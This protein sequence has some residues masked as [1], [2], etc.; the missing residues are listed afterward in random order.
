[1]LAPIRKAVVAGVGAGFFAGVAGLA[2]AMADGALTVAEATIAGGLALGALASV[3][4]ATWATA[5]ADTVEDVDGRH[6][7]PTG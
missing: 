3:G 2:A 6:E 1:M 5:N 7:A 4:S